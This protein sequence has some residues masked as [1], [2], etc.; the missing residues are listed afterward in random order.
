MS[1]SIKDLFNKFDQSNNA[2]IT[3]GKYP[4][5]IKAATFKEYGTGNRGYATLVELIDGPFKGNTV[6]GTIF[7]GKPGDV[8]KVNRFFGTLQR[9]GFEASYFAADPSWEQIGQSLVGRLV[10]VEVHNEEYNGVTSSKAKWVNAPS[11]DERN[12]YDTP[13]TQQFNPAT[14]AA[15]PQAQPAQVYAPAAEAPAQQTFAPAQA[16]VQ[17]APAEQAAP[18]LRPL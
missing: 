7:I 17:Q 10:N 18:A 13:A 2:L 14:V 9:L 11:K 8:D 3:P 6:W 1:E 15:A 4:G 16:E 5:R 12:R